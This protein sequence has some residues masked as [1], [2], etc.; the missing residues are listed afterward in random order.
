[1]AFCCP[2]EDG[3]ASLVIPGPAGP[4]T[5][6]KVPS[7]DTGLAK[8]LLNKEDGTID[9]V[10]AAGPGGGLIT[11]YMAFLMSRHLSAPDLEKFIEVHPST[12]GV[13]GLA[14]YASGLIRKQ[15]GE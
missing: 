4:G 3:S 10:C 14:K 15:K 1:L 12:D 11:G 7:R 13:Y 5:F 2:V 6:W 8:I 9:G